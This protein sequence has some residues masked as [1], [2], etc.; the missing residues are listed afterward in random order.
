MVVVK[1][2][3]G[4]ATRKSRLLCSCE[5]CVLHGYLLQLVWYSEEITLT[6]E[7]ILT[8]VNVLHKG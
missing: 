1:S 7:I 4:E 3:L 2:P 6:D 8:D 5:S